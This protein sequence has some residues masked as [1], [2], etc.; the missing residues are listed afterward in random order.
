[1]KTHDGF[2]R[3]ICETIKKHGMLSGGDSIIVCLSGGADSVALLFSLLESA[4]RLGIKSLSAVHV[5]HLIRGEEAYADERFC[6]S[7][8]ERLGVGIRV[9]HVDVPHEASES[10][11][12][13]ELAARRARYRIFDSL[14]DETGVLFATAHNMNDNAETVIH[15]L[16]RNR[17]GSALSG[18]PPV[19]GFYIRPLIETTR[20]EIEEYLGSIGESYVIDSTNSDESY[21]RNFIRHSVI[22][23][24]ETRYPSLV[25]SLFELSENMRQ[26]E[27]L[28]DYL[29]GTDMF[30]H[31]PALVKR[32]VAKAFFSASGG[33]L[34]SSSRLNSVAGAVS[35]PGGRTFS[36]SG[37]IDAVV[38]NGSFSIRPAGAALQQEIPPACLSLEDG[39]SVR[40]GSHFAV[41]V[42]FSRPDIVDRENIYNFSTTYA[43]AF[44]RIIGRT[45]TVRSR[46][47][48][49]SIR[50]GGIN[51]ILKK[52]YIN[53]KFPRF[54]R[55]AIPVVCDES[56]TV[57]VPGIGVADR[58][59]PRE[60][61]RR[62]Y[63]VF[64]FTD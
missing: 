59:R 31:D 26:D 12:S 20:P 24:L 6:I 19:R 30:P 16:L 22:P 40:F 29:A 52:E 51:R 5:N 39:C 11:E 49:D 60:G 41:S 9:F 63:L 53:R 1:M 32:R 27:R 58:V 64:E 17:A 10:G 57:A 28:L 50:F 62:L 43:L 35:L 23:L 8:C 45:L 25:R 4:G 13:L 48:G 37:E 3:R 46:A 18:I 2:C 55:P 21:T 7:L 14:H 54:L 56:G 33:G 44:D 47:A 38:E 42:S 34:L 15:S 61:D 36:L